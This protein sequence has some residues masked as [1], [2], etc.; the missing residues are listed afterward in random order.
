MNLRSMAMT[1]I[2]IIGA[3]IAGLQ[4]GL[5]L[6]QAGIAATIYTDRTADQLLASRIANIVLRSAPTRERERRLGVAHWDAEAAA[7]KRLTIRVG[8]P[9]PLSFSGFFEQ[10]PMSVDMRTYCARLL[11]DF[12][13]R[14]GRVV[15]GS[16]RAADVAALAEQ[17]DLLVVASGRGSLGT[18]F[19]R[20]PEH[21][22]YSE[23]QRVVIGGLFQGMRPG[24]PAG[25][26]IT[27]VPGHGEILA[28]PLVSWAPDLTAIGIEC[29][30]GGTLAG[31]LE[32]RYADDPA[33]HDAAILQALRQFAPEIASRC[34]PA[35]FR[36]AR[37]LDLCHVAITP[38]VRGGYTR[39]PGGRLALALGDA[40]VLND[41]LTGQGAN[42]ASYAA[43]TLGEAICRAECFDE[44]FCR[45]VEE[46]IWAYTLRITEQCN[47]RLRPPAQHMLA[48][49]GMAA[50]NQEVANFYAN[51]FNQPDRFW[52]LESS[53][54]RMM[55]FLA[56]FEQQEVAA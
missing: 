46:H 54:E 40:H 42:T 16:V 9:Q 18:L 21:S 19:P 30:P 35:T 22:P 26:D 27:V 45:E 12:A 33:G 52:E 25:L 43:L 36:L 10:A 2:G 3:G 39:L 5:R 20:L 44:P 31:L 47:R 1:T 11:A 53:A 32:L 55:A 37:P 4:L 6:R 48:L 24:Q 14:G 50:R 51:G 38:V 34:D 49:M 28:F 29:I 17:H 13:E 23:P 15:L 7:L 56:T 41:P 8:G